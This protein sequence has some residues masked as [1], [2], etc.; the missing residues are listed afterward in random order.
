LLKQTLQANFCTDS[1][2]CIPSVV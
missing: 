2:D 1:S